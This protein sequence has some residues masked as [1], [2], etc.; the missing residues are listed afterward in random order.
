MEDQA[1]YR[2]LNQDE[3]PAFPKTSAYSGTD[4]DEILGPVSG[5][6]SGGPFAAL[7][8]GHSVAPAARQLAKPHATRLASTA[9]RIPHSSGLKP[10][11][12]EWVT[13]CK[14][15]YRSFDETTGLVLTFAGDK[16]MCP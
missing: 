2:C 4:L 16:L 12:P 3:A 11:S 13:W 14:Q 5:G 9:N 1:Y 7:D 15:H 10:R 6:Q 8:Q